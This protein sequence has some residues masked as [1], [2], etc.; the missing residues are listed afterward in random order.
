MF[1]EP[2]ER[3]DELPPDP[4]VRAKEKSDE[5]RIHAELAAVFEGP[6]KF[7]ARVV[8]GLDPE[9]T[10]D[11]QR[12]IAKLEKAKTP[13]SPVLPPT[14]TADAARLLGIPHERGLPAGDYHV[15][16]RPG[17]VMIVRW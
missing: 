16:R 4:A 9:L 15:H 12:T 3:P 10:R 7:D 1:D 14:A 11:V 8:P 5:F 2:S 17:E 6:R 13:D